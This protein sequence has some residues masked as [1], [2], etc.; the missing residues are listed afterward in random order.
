MAITFFTQSRKQIAPIWIRYRELNTDAKARTNLYIDKDRLK[1]SKV[2][3]HKMSAKDN[4]E[5][6][7]LVKE[8]NKALDKVQSEMQLLE[9]RIRSLVSHNT[10]VD[11]AWLKRALRPPEEVMKLTLLDYYQELLNSNANLSNN[12]QK[13]YKVNATFMLRYEKHIG[14]VLQV[15]DI[16]GNFKDAFVK[17]CRDNGYPESTIKGQLGRL[18]AV[19]LYAEERGET[20]HNQV[21]NLSKGIKIQPTESVF[22]TPSEIESII[23]LKLKDKPLGFAKDWLVISCYIGQRSVSLFRLSKENIDVKTNTIRLTQVKTKASVVIPILPQVSAILKKHKGDFPPLLSSKPKHNYNVY[24][25]S[26]KEVCKL[27][28]IDELCKGRI[29]NI[30]GAVSKVVTKPKHELVTSHVG[31]RSF[32]SNFYGKL[33]Q[34]LIMGVTGHKSE[35]SFL[36]YINKDREIDA[37]ALNSAFLNAMQ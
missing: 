36:K 8:K 23:T 12:T 18:K 1:G 3:K 14:R 31:R 34:Q 22:L 13:S 17:H 26:I 6:K 21:K 29:R 2:L 10:Q 37:E 5:Q 35:S 25:D 16:D 19:C 28:K 30:G 9:V 11:S 27:A 24:N 15:S 4:Q 32:A 7:L 20:I 33:N